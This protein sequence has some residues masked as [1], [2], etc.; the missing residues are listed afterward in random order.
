[1]DYAANW[2][3]ACREAMAS[4]RGFAIINFENGDRTFF[5]C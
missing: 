5:N 4:N 3:A 2:R 1:M